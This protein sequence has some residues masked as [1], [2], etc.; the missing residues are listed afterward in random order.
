MRNWSDFRNVFLV[1]V[2]AV[3]AVLLLGDVCVIG[4][5]RKVVSEA[6]IL[7]KLESPNSWDREYGAR[8]AAQNGL[9]VL[10]G[11]LAD[12]LTDEHSDVRSS[13]IAALADLGIRESAPEIAL[14]LTDED[15]G[16][17]TEAVRAVGRLKFREAKEGLMVALTDKKGGV[18]Q[19]AIAALGLLGIS[20]AGDE[21]QGF[22]TS[23]DTEFR[24]AACVALAR[25]RHVAA[26]EA[27][28]ELLND[29]RPS[30][31]T[32]ALQCL[33][34]LRR[35]PNQ[36]A[37]RQLL[38]SR[39]FLVRSTAIQ[40]I[41]DMK[42][43]EMAPDLVKLIPD[44]DPLIEMLAVGTLGRF[45]DK[46]VGKVVAAVAFDGKKDVMIRRAAILALGRIDIK[47]YVGQIKTLVS[48][49]NPGVRFAA[50]RALGYA[51][52]PHL[53]VI[54]EGVS[55]EDKELRCQMAA[56]VAL[57]ACGKRDA[58]KVAEALLSK[59]EKAGQSDLFDLIVLLKDL[60]RVTAD[61]SLYK[62]MRSQDAETRVIASMILARFLSDD[63]PADRFQQLEKK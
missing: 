25:L 13:A 36:P 62:L 20:E 6:D 8:L 40:A 32:T 7:K 51:K 48:D 59:V 60:P 22:L 52:D 5:P 45:G 9:K 46:D 21:I 49:P 27:I 3:F 17:R 54:L 35:R 30:I 63:T 15:A 18:V 44:A 11:R 37:M 57:V 39:S 28:A 56:R 33:V 12:L 10:S 31:Q 14:L 58:S 61:E 34:A 24:R 2:A 19:A 50:I 53:S 43:R 55:R 29:P 47:G 16:V 26:A 4:Q 1:G 41:G 42:Y 23:D 38:N